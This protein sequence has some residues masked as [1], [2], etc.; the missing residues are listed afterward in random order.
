MYRIWWKF[1]GHDGDNFADCATVA[2]AQMTWDAINGVPRS[3]MLCR[4]P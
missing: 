2:Q 1:Q 3:V 4:R